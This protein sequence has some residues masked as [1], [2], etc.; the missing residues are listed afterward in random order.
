MAKAPIPSRGDIWLVNFD[1][2]MG[3]EMGKLRPAL[4]MSLDTIGN[5]PLRIVAPITDWKPNYAGLPW[6]M[7]LR[8]NSTNQLAKHSG[9]DAFQVK[10]ISLARFVRRIGAATGREFEATASATIAL[11]VGTP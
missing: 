1:P 9:I 3:A 10:S 2:T 7:A 5:L 11:C 4:V 6:F 8:P